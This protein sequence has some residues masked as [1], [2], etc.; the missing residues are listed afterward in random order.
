MTLSGL[1]AG[2]LQTLGPAV[3]TQ[4]LVAVLPLTGALAV[5]AAGMTWPSTLTRLGRRAEHA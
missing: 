5:V 3:A 1:G 4:A 2:A